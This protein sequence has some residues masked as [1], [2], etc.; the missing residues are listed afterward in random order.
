MPCN[1]LRWLRSAKTDSVAVRLV[2]V[3]S[4]STSPRVDRADVPP[5]ATPAPRS[6]D[7]RDQAFGSQRFHRPLVV[8]IEAGFGTMLRPAMN[9][10]DSHLALG[11]RVPDA[12]QR[13]RASREWHR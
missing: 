4:P 3:D 12:V 5:S 6:R 8:A 1:S 13:E 7:N 10:L 2:A 9:H 11:S